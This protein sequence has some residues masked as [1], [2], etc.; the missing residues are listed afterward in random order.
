MIIAFDVDFPWI[1]RPGDLADDSAGGMYWIFVT[2][3]SD[4]LTGHSMGFC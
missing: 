2:K 4:F 1:F 3:N